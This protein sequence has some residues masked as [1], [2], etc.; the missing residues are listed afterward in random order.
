MILRVR[1]LVI[2]GYLLL[3]IS[4]SLVTLAAV[5]A[6]EISH[7]S[8]LP[9]SILILITSVTGF[10]FFSSIRSGIFILGDRIE[11]HVLPF[12]FKAFYNEIDRVVEDNELTGRY[13][14]VTKG[15]KRIPI[16]SLWFDNTPQIVALIRKKTEHR[17]EQAN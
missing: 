15:G 14:V 13:F 12:L 6:L 2:F 1:R 16:S 3:F 17:N 4:T 10:M 5:I 9:S 8:L 7:N 11:V